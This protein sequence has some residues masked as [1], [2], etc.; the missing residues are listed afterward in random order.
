LSPASEEELS[1]ASPPHSPMS[2]PAPSQALPQTTSG[3]AHSPSSTPT[4]ACRSHNSFP[5]FPPVAAAGTCPSPSGL[6]LQYAQSLHFAV[7]SVNALRLRHERC[8]IKQEDYTSVMSC[9]EDSTEASPCHRD[10]DWFIKLLQAE[11]ERLEGWCQQMER[12]A[13][14]NDLPEEVLEKIRSA[15]GSAQL[16]MS[17]KFQQFFRLCQQNMDPNAFPLPTSQDLAGFW[18]LLQLSVEDVT[19]KFDELL[20]IKSNNWVLI[21]MTDKQVSGHLPGNSFQLLLH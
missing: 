15:V 6:C 3:P 7:N 4:S 17:Q 5:G 14:E 11:V 8:C 18:D 1:P 2:G 20:Q 10:G 13:E 12:E 9:C 19:L 21:D 16:L